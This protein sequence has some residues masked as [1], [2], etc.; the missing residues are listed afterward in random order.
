MGGVFA[1]SIFLGASLGT[2]FGKVAVQSIQPI[3]DI[4]FWR[5]AEYAQQSWLQLAI[6][7]PQSYALVSIT[8]TLGAI[9]RVPL[10]GI[11]LLFELTR[12]YTSIVPAIGAVG[13]S[14]YVSS[15]ISN[16]LNHVRLVLLSAHSHTSLPG[17]GRT[18]GQDTRQQ[19]AVLTRATRPSC[20]FPLGL[21]TQAYE[22]WVRGGAPPPLTPSQLRKA[23]K[24]AAAAA[25]AQEAAA[26]QLDRLSIDMVLDAQDSSLGRYVVVSEAAGVEEVLD[27]LRVQS[28]DIAVVTGMDGRWDLGAAH[29]SP[30]H[31]LLAASECASPPSS[32]ASSGSCHPRTSRSPRRPR[33]RRRSRWPKRLR[34][35]WWRGRR[36]QPQ[37]PLP[38]RPPLP[39]PPHPPRSCPD[40]TRAQN[41]PF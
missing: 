33:R 4:L 25:A 29:S 11:A 12:N 36:P 1:P 26:A 8:A 16:R 23:A 9:C 24:A 3:N 30:S 18:R 19:E 20:F 14:F 31:R 7:A 37:P 38:L 28:A 13:I 39:R 41:L 10:T 21:E 32:A 22:A 35:P 2:A 40:S 6:S 17:V 15:A 27:M 34:Q 5:G